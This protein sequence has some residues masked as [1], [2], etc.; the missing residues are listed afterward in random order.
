M[1][2]FEMETEFEVWCGTCGAGICSETDVRGM[3]VTVECSNCVRIH[4]LEVQELESRIEQLE[5]RIE[6]LEDG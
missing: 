5:A 2:T 4:E 3:T 1:P 6:E